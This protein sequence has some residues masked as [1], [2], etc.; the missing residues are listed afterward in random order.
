MKCFI[1][2]TRQL[3]ITNIM[4]QAQTQEQLIRLS[5]TR[6]SYVYKGKYYTLNNKMY[7][8]ENAARFY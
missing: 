3:T 7:I 6:K 1:L 8:C 4:A 5:K 2:F